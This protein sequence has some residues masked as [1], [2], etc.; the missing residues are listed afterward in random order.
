MKKL[1]ALL[2][3]FIL[4]FSLTACS[5]YSMP[6]ENLVQF[7]WLEDGTKQQTPITISQS[8][9]WVIVS[10]LNAGVWVE[11]GVNA[12]DDYQFT[13]NGVRMGYI[14]SGFF[15]EYDRGYAHLLELSEEDTQR[16]N[17]ILG[18]EG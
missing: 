7:H 5:Q 2:L 13:V 17:K 6:I 10:I 12:P 14:A 11:D 3:V 16:V 8:E 4:I 9:Q 15:R 1:F 18:F